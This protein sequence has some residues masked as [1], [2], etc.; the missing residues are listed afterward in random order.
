MRSFQILTL[1]L[2]LVCSVCPL[3]GCSDAGAGATGDMEQPFSTGLSSE[4]NHEEITADGLYFLRPDVIALLQGFNVATDV[5]FFFESRYHFDDCNFSQAAQTVAFE[6]SA[7]VAALDP[8]NVT[9]ESELLA[10]QAFGHALHSVQDFYAHTNWVELG[11]T[12]LV[13]R[14]LDAWP[15][16][17]PYATIGS[18]TVVVVEGPPPKRVSVSR[19]HDAPYPDN[20][21][22]RVRSR[23]RHSPGLISGTVDYE[24]GDACPRQ[25]AMTHDEL[26]KDRA[27]IAGRTLQ[28]EQAKALGIAQTT[29]EW[30]RLVALT[31]AAWGEAGE[32]RLA[33]WIALGATAPDCGAVD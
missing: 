20:A 31:R 8:A 1:S 2:S 11:M 29:H 9:P 17:E 27:T 23:A 21:V 10:L 25:V 12:D 32:Q 18:S 6:E 14:S 22:V 24:P 16:L 28:H 15:A 13:D 30:C 5:Q 26:N 19:D 4:P 33:S 7:A 3:S